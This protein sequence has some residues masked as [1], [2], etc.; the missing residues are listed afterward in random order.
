MRGCCVNRR[1][2]AENIEAGDWTTVLLGI[3]VFIVVAAIAVLAVVMI[4]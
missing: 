4:F 1:R 3:A 2:I